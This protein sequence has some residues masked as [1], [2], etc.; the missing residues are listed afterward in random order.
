MAQ[1]CRFSQANR[2][3]WHQAHHKLLA[4][5]GMAVRKRSFLPLLFDCIN[6]IILLV[7]QDRLGTNTSTGKTTRLKGPFL[8]ATS[9]GGAHLPDPGPDAAEERQRYAGAR[10]PK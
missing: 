1:K 6:A 9:Y 4:P 7:N 10:R 3:F 2:P 5:M 8:Q